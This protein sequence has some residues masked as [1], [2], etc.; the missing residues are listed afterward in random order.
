[1][2]T[3]SHLLT[4]YLSNEDTL[5]LNNSYK[6]RTNFKDD[7]GKYCK[8]FYYNMFPNIYENYLKSLD[9]DYLF[10][11]H[12]GAGTAGFILKIKPHL[13][14]NNMIKLSNDYELQRIK[15]S[16]YFENNQIPAEMVIKV[17]LLYNDDKDSEAKVLREELIM[18]ELNTKKEFEDFIPQFYY[19]FTLNAPFSDGIMKVRCTFM[20]YI[21]NH[22]EQILKLIE[23]ETIINKTVITQLEILVKKLWK[24]GISHN[25]LSIRNVLSNGTK[26]KLVDFG[27]STMIDPRNLFSNE[28]DITISEAYLKYFKDKDKTDQNGSNVNMMNDLFRILNN[29]INTH[30]GGKLCTNLR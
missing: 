14:V 25:D 23:N 2:S 9:S 21:D 15:K 1:M 26:V 12:V 28:S 17:Q 4:K 19:G 11:L 13:F 20:G 29:Y 7:R 27:L 22:Y 18:K 24:Y 6:N 16:T 30:R 5:S 10:P 8:E 3:I